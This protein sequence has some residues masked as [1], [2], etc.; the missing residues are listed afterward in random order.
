MEKST[1]ICLLLVAIIS[2]LVNSEKELDPPNPVER[3]PPS[4]S[5]LGTYHN[6]AVTSICKPCAAAGR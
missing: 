2:P 4:S 5:P 1:L 3:P 6:G